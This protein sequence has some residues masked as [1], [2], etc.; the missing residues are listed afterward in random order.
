MNEQKVAGNS[1]TSVSDH[2]Q[3]SGINYVYAGENTRLVQKQSDDSDKNGSA[4]MF[5][6]SIPCDVPREE[7]SEI[8]PNS[9]SNIEKE[10]YDGNIAEIYLAAGSVENTKHS[11]S[12]DSNLSEMSNSFRLMEDAEADCDVRNDTQQQEGVFED[13]TELNEIPNSST[14]NKKRPLSPSF[15][16][17]EPFENKRIKVE[18]VSYAS[19]SAD[20][21]KGSSEGVVDLCPPVAVVA[22]LGFC[23][24]ILMDSSSAK[25][26]R[27]ES[28]CIKNDISS[29][30][31]S[32][33]QDNEKNP[34]LFDAVFEK[35]KTDIIDGH[36]FKTL[37]GNNWT[38]DGK[39]SYV[40]SSSKASE[41]L[42]IFKSE[43]ENSVKREFN[44]ANSVE[45]DIKDFE[46]VLSSVIEKA[47]KIPKSSESF[48]PKYGGALPVSCVQISAPNTQC[49]QPCSHVANSDLLRGLLDQKTENNDKQTKARQ[50]I[51]LSFLH[52]ELVLGKGLSVS[53]DK[54]LQTRSIDPRSTFLPHVE[55]PGGASQ[56]KSSDDESKVSNVPTAVKLLEDDKMSLAEQR[57]ASVTLHHKVPSQNSHQILQRSASTEE[58]GAF[59]GTNIIK[60]AFDFATEISGCANDENDNAS[61]QQYSVQTSSRPQGFTNGS[62]YASAKTGEYLNRNNFDYSLQVDLT[63]NNQSLRN[64]RM[65]NMQ[66]G[67]GLLTFANP[68]GLQSPGTSLPPQLAGPFMNS[69]ES[70]VSGQQDV[71]KQME[72]NQRAILSAHSNRNG[73][74]GS[75]IQPHPSQNGAVSNDNQMN[76]LGMS[77]MNS[78]Q[79]PLHKQNMS[80]M[81]Q[82]P[83]TGYPL[84]SAGYNTNMSRNVLSEFRQGP[85]ERESNFRYGSRHLLG[86][87]SRAPSPSENNFPMGMQ[88]R[89]RAMN[90][91]Q[92]YRRRM[93]AQMNHPANP[94]TQQMM[95]Q[96]TMAQGQGLGSH[97]MM[98]GQGM[99]P[100]TMA[101]AQG[102][103]P[104]PMA[105]GQRLGLQPNSAG[106]GH[107]FKP[108]HTQQEVGP[109][110]HPMPQVQDIDPRRR[111]LQTQIGH[112]TNQTVSGNHNM[113]PN[114][115]SHVQ[116]HISHENQSQGLVQYRQQIN[117][118]NRTPGAEVPDPM[119]IQRPFSTDMLQANPHKS[120]VPQG[121]M[122]QQDSF[123]SVPHQDLF[124]FDL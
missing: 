19:N 21:S 36:S 96:H 22:P 9:H 95:Q 117:Q 44:R 6:D 107:R 23:E 108:S 65:Q 112:M 11:G 66:V 75:E 55:K 16:E 4:F 100:H 84:N 91:Q 26:P 118:M 110:S 27:K 25:S 123:S 104:Y 69:A 87:M 28:D 90:V 43:K 71:R 111:A 35:M 68:G 2:Q 8:S 58:S 37:D 77:K 93:Q 1:S 124:P 60:E 5:D 13:K 116:D 109:T 114:N 85:G 14:E 89:I 83:T 56:T 20:E 88:E 45:H 46:K 115:F 103:G 82:N 31:D 86:Q 81:A 10:L 72:F 18:P 67:N 30:L 106:L 52:S 79:N 34:F 94:Q 40:A 47:N 51:D 59:G 57:R 29:I 78:L 74:V 120:N 33:E 38:F 101:H 73:P 7:K 39:P 64:S 48:I 12:S 3:T 121:D 63:Q 92:W 42:D 49:Q 17:N 99:G 80:F 119:Q 98:Q 32:L 102:I 122:S 54:I 76:H 97:Q 50:E 61:S 70:P 41:N 15:T 105:Q 113:L 53:S 24:D 62:L